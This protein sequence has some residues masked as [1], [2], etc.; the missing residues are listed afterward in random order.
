[1]SRDV[2]TSKR[3]LAGPRPCGK[4]GASVIMRMSSRRGRK[5]GVALV[6]LVLLGALV[7][8][9]PA[10]AA[11]P[12]AIAK[13]KD[14]VAQTASE[15][16]SV[17]Q[18]ALGAVYGGVSL[19]NATETVNVLLTSLSAQAEAT[20]KAGVS[21]PERLR[22]TQGTYTVQQLVAL[23]KRIEGDYD[24]LTGQGIH[25]SSVGLGFGVVVV[26]V[27]ESNPEVATL[28]FNR[29][30]KHALKVTLGRVIRTTS[31]QTRKGPPPYMGGMEVNDVGNPSTVGH[32]AYSECTA[33]FIAD[34]FI[35]GVPFY[36]IL[37]AGHCF[38][39]AQLVYHAL[40][41]GGYTSV[42]YVTFNSWY[43]GTNADTAAVNIQGTSALAT[44]QIITA[45]PYVHTVDYAEASQLMNLPVCHSGITTDQHCN[46]TNNATHT[47][48]YAREGQNGPITKE[49]DQVGACCDYS[50]LG[51]SGG[52]VY[53]YYQAQ[54]INAE[55][56]QSAEDFDAN[57]VPTGQIWYSFIQNVRDRTGMNICTR[58]PNST[59]GC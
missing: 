10:V 58:I 7:A 45:E 12:T 47:T 36:Y 52:P 32:L 34:K 54:S 33:G 35:R 21:H 9:A 26:S 55:G 43:D 48:V 38:N 44:N 11:D 5:V 15:A 14:P 17:G 25:L 13:V 2:P 42:G 6:G 49:I 8:G 27:Q 4:Q 37:T 29:Y 16:D 23:Q 39:P 31:T 18:G 46:F 22:F 41:N 30:G 19:D 1:M 28:L 51:D 57:G 53:H 24:A 56:L 40:S 20:L 59:T 3:R 50:Y